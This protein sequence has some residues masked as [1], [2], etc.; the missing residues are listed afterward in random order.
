[1]KTLLSSLDERIPTDD[2]AFSQQEVAPL[3]N[4]MGMLEKQMEIFNS[5]KRD[6]DISAQK[7][8]QMILSDEGADTWDVILEQF[9][10]MWFA[11]R[12]QLGAKFLNLYVTLIRQRKG[13][14][15]APLCGIPSDRLV[16]ADEM[17]IS[18]ALKI[19]ESPY[20]IPGALN[21]PPVE[22]QCDNN[23]TKTTFLKA[24]GSLSN[25]TYILHT[26][27]SVRGDV[28]MQVGSGTSVAST[29]SG[30]A[31]RTT[32]L[33]YARHLSKNIGTSLAHFGVVVED[34]A[35]VHACRDVAS[36]V[37]LSQ[38]LVHAKLMPSTTTIHAL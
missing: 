22:M 25:S 28:L 26:G 19:N 6:L 16:F 2:L 14:F 7:R 13:R 35:S 1:M 12:F 11:E 37:Y 36:A 31:N 3:K 15:P 34:G 17:P 20:V 32:C 24:S 9:E 8:T 23:Q 27:Q 5:K 10:K 29:A 30:T 18:S 33:G 4:V 38:G 21:A